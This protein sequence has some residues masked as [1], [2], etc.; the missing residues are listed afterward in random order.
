[1]IFAYWYI[2]TFGTCMIIVYIFSIYP[3]LVTNYHDILFFFFFQHQGHPYIH[4]TWLHYTGAAS[5][6]PSLYE[7][8]S[9]NERKH[10]TKVALKHTVISIAPRP[11]QRKQ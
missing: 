7:S 10:R 2:T 3:D 8:T 1:M 6:L 9:K 5:I 4:T 11:R